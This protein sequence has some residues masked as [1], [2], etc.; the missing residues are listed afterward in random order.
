MKPVVKFIN[1]ET[2]SKF[3]SITS[4]K[5]WTSPSF[6]TFHLRL[7][8]H[9]FYSSA[10]IID[11]PV[12]PDRL[13]RFSGPRLAH[14]WAMFCVV[15]PVQWRHKAKLLPCIG[16]C[17]VQP[18]LKG[19]AH[20]ASRSVIMGLSGA[21]IR[22]LRQSYTNL[23]PVFVAPWHPSCWYAVTCFAD[24]NCMRI[25]SPTACMLC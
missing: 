15:S 12:N 13:I 19:L 5:L 22:D 6:D 18:V 24:L 23:Y 3:T 17:L 16:R 10:R 4:K 20:R 8:V 1:N 9:S 11:N 7:K 14:E 25:T 21:C 2:I